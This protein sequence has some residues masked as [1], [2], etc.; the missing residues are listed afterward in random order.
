MVGARPE[1]PREAGYLRI[2]AMARATGVPAATLRAWER[3]YGVP[4]PGR[5]E[6]RY[7]LY[8]EA[9]LQLV[10]RMVQLTRLGLG[11]AE[12]ARQALA[13][14]RLPLAPGPP[15]PAGEGW[16]PLP[17]AARAIVEAAARLDPAGIEQA[18]RDALAGDR[19]W[20]AYRDL[21]APALRGLGEAWASGWLG[22]AGEHLASRVIE[23]ALDEQLRELTLAPDAP[24]LLLASVAGELHALPL[25]GVAL[26]AAA[27]GWRALLLG[28]RVPPEA[29]AE[30]VRRLDPD[31]VGLSVIVPVLDA[32]PRVL[33]TAYGQAVGGRPW[34][35]G[36]DAA[37]LYQ[38]LYASLGGELAGRDAGELARFLA[39]A[40]RQRHPQG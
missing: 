33:F 27:S 2:Q 23:R 22:V 20:E 34:I 6:N 12:A 30:A 38:P 24:R 28:S 40:A 39:R 3:R 21:L 16:T 10:L 17:P 29:L 14:E 26:E 5:G 37:A 36:G 25:L 8:D 7:R 15:T 1:E 13:E 19:P 9:D 35:L 31:A 11:P 18:V 4:R 32:D